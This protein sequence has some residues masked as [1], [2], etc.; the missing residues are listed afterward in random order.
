MS[1]FLA[2]SSS[3]AAEFDLTTEDIQSGTDHFV[4]QLGTDYHIAQTRE[5]Y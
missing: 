5:W 3:I 4:R 2:H 1:Y